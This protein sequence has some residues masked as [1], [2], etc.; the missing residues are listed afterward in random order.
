MSHEPSLAAK[1]DVPVI[2]LSM[3][4]GAGEAWGKSKLTVYL[5]SIVELIII[6]NPWQ[7]SSRLRASALRAFGAKIGKEVILRPRLRV[8]HPW[9]LSIG[10]RS[11]I[12]DGVWIHNRDTVTIGHDVVISQQT[13]ITTGSH[14]HRTDMAL[15]TKPVLIEDGAWVASRCMVMGGVRVG[16]SAL[17]QPM[18]SVRCDVPANAILG[19]HPPQIIGSRFA[20]NDVNKSADS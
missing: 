2:D 3:A 11:W 17:V 20:V 10:D 15:R 19:P 14:A 8:R 6:T 1:A 7:I 13:F 4:P 12:G 9:K 16:R 18:T 5:W